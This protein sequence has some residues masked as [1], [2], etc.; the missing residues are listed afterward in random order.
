MDERE[1]MKEGLALLD[2]AKICMLGT[3]GGDGYPNI[4]AMMNMKTLR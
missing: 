3:N 1:A 2:R 4:K